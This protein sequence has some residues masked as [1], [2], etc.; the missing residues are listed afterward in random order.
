[1]DEAEQPGEAR[2][3]SALGAWVLTSYADV[4]AALRDARLSL[5]GTSAE[6]DAAHVAVGE[7]AARALSPARLAAWRAELEASALVLA[8]ALPTDSPV[9]LVGAFARPWSVA[10]A[11]RATGAPAADAERLDRLAREVFLAAA[12]AT[13]SGFPPRAQAAAAELASGFPSAGASADVQAYVALS[14]TLPRVLANAWLELFRRP[15]EA[16]RLRAHPELMPGA[17]EEL[18]RHASPARAVFRRSLAEMSIGRASVAPGDRVILM[19][20]AAN[21]DPARFPEPGR[22]DVGRDAAGHLAFGPGAH[23]CPGA[24]LIRMA[25][26]VATD[27]LLRM[28]SAVEPVGDVEWIGG[29]AIRA[30]ATLPVVL[31]REP[32]DHHVSSA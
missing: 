24:P 23:S 20:S 12:H 27:A 5:S 28:T 22:L 15:D 9:D 6:G 18:L 13:D 3:D 31:R 19:L 14:Q 10:L 2:F 26:A 1:M 25:V 11:V 4:S 8:G 16:D 30:P 7:A 29:F 17:V 32:V 21:H